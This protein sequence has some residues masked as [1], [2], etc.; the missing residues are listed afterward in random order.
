M[1]VKTYRFLII[2]FI[3]FFS[4]LFQSCRTVFPNKGEYI[5]CK[6]ELV[7]PV[8][9]PTQRS[10]F[11]GG[12]NEMMKFIA[13]NMNLPEESLKGDIRVSFITTKDGDICDF[14]VVSKSKE[15]IENEI[16]RIFSIMPKWIPA[17]NNG[18][19]VDCYNYIKF[20]F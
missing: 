8:M 7:L 3:V 16:I 13:N 17:E 20:K 5:N 18:E 1:N 4:T 14:R 11:P 2:G 12:S 9:N 19:I 15:H 10:S 6:G